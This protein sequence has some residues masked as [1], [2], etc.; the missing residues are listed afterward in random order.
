MT[1]TLDAVL[2]GAVVALPNTPASAS[3]V[4]VGA[5]GGSGASVLAAALADSAAGRGVDV[6]LLDLAPPYV[7]GLGATA[8][9]ATTHPTSVDAVTLCAGYRP[10]GAH[11]L[12]LDSEVS[13]LRDNFWPRQAVPART[14]WL[15]YAHPLTIVDFSWRVVETVL[16]SARL[17]EWLTSASTIVLAV[18]G[19]ARG[20]DA[21]ESVAV[22]LAA[23]GSPTPH[24]VVTRERKVPSIITAGAGAHLSAAIDAHGV[25]AFPEAPEVRLH[26]ATDPFPS[27][28]VKSA[29][30][31]LLTAVPTLTK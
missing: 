13:A 11:L 7:S 10:S 24:V 15:A 26:G 28:L 30:D 8:P 31:H 3:V 4:V 19:T 25:H 1:M 18:P 2:G 27:S 29:T 9:R 17:G 20:V 6:S 14:E 22:A 5:T 16:A 21:A 23:V 12:R